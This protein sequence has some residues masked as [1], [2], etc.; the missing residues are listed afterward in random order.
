M[1]KYEQTD[2]SIHKTLY[3]FFIFVTLYCFNLYAS[4][5]WRKLL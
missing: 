4:Q 5:F 2:F 3:L 1:K